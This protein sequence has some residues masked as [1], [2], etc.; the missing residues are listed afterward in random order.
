MT[1]PEK[2]PGDTTPALCWREAG[3]AHIRF[4]RPAALNAIDVRMAQAFFD[5]CRRIADDAEVRVVVISGEGRAF[6]AGGDIAAMK[7][8]P[9]AVAKELIAGMHGGIEILAGLSAPVIASVHG[10]VAGGGLGLA[11]AC[12]LGIAAEGTRFNLAYPKLGTSSDCATS[13]AL[14]RLLGLRKAL[15]IALLSEPIDA[16]EALRLGLVNRVVPADQLVAETHA[17]ARKLADGPREALGRL[18]HLIRESAHRDL[19]AQLDAEAES[20]LACAGTADFAEG[21]NAF[22]EKRPPQFGK[23]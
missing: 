20:F 19:R 6:M 5:G 3:I 14:P 13:W 7:H 21:L 1:Y 18:K 11:L 15:E 17:M 10:A 4:N 22:T 16:Q 12:D 2:Q 8:D 9:Q 23:R